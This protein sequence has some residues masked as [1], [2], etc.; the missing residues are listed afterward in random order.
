[1][2]LESALDFNSLRQ[3]YQSLFDSGLL[4]RHS[5]GRDVVDSS[6]YSFLLL[7]AH[8]SSVL[9]PFGNA[10]VKLRTQ[11]EVYVHKETK[12]ELLKLQ[13]TVAFYA[14]DREAVSKL[15]P[16]IQ[17]CIAG[18]N[19]IHLLERFD[20][21]LFRSLDSGLQQWWLTDRL[22][23]DLMICDCSPAIR[24]LALEYLHKDVPLSKE[25][26]VLLATMC[27]ASGNANGLEEMGKRFGDS[28]PE[29]VAMRCIIQGQ[30]DEARSQLDRA[31]TLQKSKGTKHRTLDYFSETMRLLLAIRQLAPKQIANQID[32]ACKTIRSGWPEPLNTIGFFVDEVAK[33]FSNEFDF[34]GRFDSFCRKKP[35]FAALVAGYIWIWLHDRP[36]TFPVERIEAAGQ[37]YRQAGY[38]WLA[39]EMK[40]IE[41]VEA[42]RVRQLSKRTPPTN[43]TSEKIPVGAWSLLVREKPQSDWREPLMAIR[44]ALGESVFK[45]TA[46]KAPSVSEASQRLIWEIAFSEGEGSSFKLQPF[47]QK[48]NKNGWTGGQ[49]VA[50]NRLHNDNQD[51]SIEPSCDGDRQ[52]MAAIECNI[53]RNHYGYTE[54]NYWLD[55]SK[56]INGIVGHPAI[57]MPGDRTAPLEIVHGSPQLTIT[58]TDSAILWRITP[59]PR[60]GVVARLDGPHRISL[61]T[62]TPRQIQIGEIIGKEMLFPLQSAS[63]LGPTIRSLASHFTVH[64]EIGASDSKADSVKANS[65]LIAQIKPAGSGLQFHWRVRPFGDCGP[66]SQPGLGSK[67]LLATVDGQPK[68]TARDLAKEAT[69]MRSALEKLPSL[70]EAQEWL[71]NHP[72][73]SAHA[74]PCDFTVEF[75]DNALAVL[76]ELKAIADAGEVEMQWP[77]GQSLKLA[78][79][80]GVANLRV[81]IKKDRD[82][83][84][85][86]G[87]LEL[88]KKTQLELSTFID[89]I[90]ATPSRFI[91]INEDRFIAVSEQLRA[92]IKE[93]A[94]FTQLNGSNRRF[95]SQH[96]PIL[97]EIA[98][99]FTLKGDPAWRKAMERWE[100]SQTIAPV[101]PPALQAQLRDYQFD[102]YQWLVRMAGWG[103]GV[104]LADDMGLGK[105]IQVLAL[106]L[107]RASGGPALVV[108]PSSVTF[109]WEE[110]SSQYA[111]S[112]NV[113]IFGDGNRKEFFESLGANDIVIC[114]YTLLQ[115]E[116][117]LFEKH[118]WHSV[119]LDEA[120]AIKNYAA[121][122]SQAAM[123]LKTDFRM[124]LTGTPIENHLGELWSLFEFINPGF[125]GS[126]K[127]FQERFAVPIERDQNR[128]VRQALK[129]LLRPFLLRRLK[130]EVLHELPSKTET[131]IRIEMSEPE[132]LLYEAIRQRAVKS[133]ADATSDSKS[134]ES[135]RLQILAEIMR[136][137]RACCHPK[138]VLPDSDIQGSKLTAFSE[139]IEQLRENGHRVL[140]FSQFVDH[141]RLL[142]SELERLQVRYQYLDGSTPTKLRKQSVEAFQRGEGDVFLI[143]LRAGGFGL[144]LV[145]ADYVI[146]MDPWWNPAVEDQA[147]DRAHRIGQTRPVTIYRFIA[148]GTIEDK[149]LDLHRSKRSLA[150]ELLADSDTAGKLSAE[151]LMELL[152]R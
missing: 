9:S 138:L 101:V 134:F 34:L 46:P 64:S 72:A 143:S 122:R 32:I 49:R 94:S 129:R 36:L 109:G 144:N 135:K 63:E 61:I 148:A 110:Q 139:T 22:R 29:T 98:S 87:T 41:T 136:L 20:E 75:L 79:S 111:P 86:T 66:F 12:A 33:D 112:L 125:L 133:I 85:L 81:Q 76:E 99:V 23:F 80:A 52:L 128:T 14:N 4:V 50:M 142:R 55:E 102:G 73:D 27:F 130:S 90:E 59:E 56:A 44:V 19:S 43:E 116:S 10:I 123:K 54:T 28:I 131:T 68:S 95:T 25:M 30:V 71:A 18:P 152:L 82:W 2:P 132:Q 108:A 83:F 100:A 93:I 126:Q 88:D 35:P 145:G 149:I 127:D 60:E 77:N 26:V 147:S 105:T 78:G 42:Q 1:M 47:L 92:R 74:I 97:A 70:L 114:S 17:F 24:A 3:D 106:L 104:C 121:K 45:S 115:L 48:R 58:K 11:P 7:E 119:V 6:L 146:H 140:V 15:R 51:G 69:Q 39:D 96:A 120:Q 124:I 89:L 67:H 117:G 150:D 53:S 16:S 38:N 91:K 65:K 84:A 21:S 118:P 5:Y 103:A 37:A 151:Q 8:R 137:R 31:L 107:E 40:R 57:Y 113:K 62:F 13:L 141:L